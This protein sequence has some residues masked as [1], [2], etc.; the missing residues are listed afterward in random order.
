MSGQ[1]RAAYS[2]DGERWVEGVD[3]GE[4]GCVVAEVIG[5]GVVPVDFRADG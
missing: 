5:A 2:A 3:E 4:E 1:A